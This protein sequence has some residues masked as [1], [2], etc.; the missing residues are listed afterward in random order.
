M[1][2]ALTVMNIR[3]KEVLSQLH[4][5]SGLAII[6]AILN[7]ERNKD[8]LVELCH[9][10][11]LKT[12]KELILKSLEVKYTEAG[13]FALKQA[14]DGYKFYLSQIEECDNKIN[15][16]INRIGNSGTGQEIKKKE[17]IF[18]IINHLLKNSHPT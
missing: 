2:K 15:L 5:V 1:Q 4:G 16:V 12:K 9:K 6:E 14:Y 3:L 10:S 18:G 7:G 8:I 17:K 13:L 11:V